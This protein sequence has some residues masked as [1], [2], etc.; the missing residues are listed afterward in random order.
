MKEILQRLIEGEK[1]S[2]QESKEV[3]GNITDNKYNEYEITAF[4]TIY[5]MRPITPKELNGFREALVERAVKV[6]LD[7]KGAIDLC[8]TGGDGK[9][10]FNISTLAALITAGAG[11]RVIKH[12]NYGVSSS[13]GSSN[14]LEACGYTLTNDEKVLQKQLEVGNFCYLH[15][16][17][18]HPSMKAVAP[19][20]RGLGMKTFFNLLGPLVNP[21][22]PEFQIAGVFDTEVA[23][24]YQAILTPIRKNFAVLHSC[25]GYDEISLT[26]NFYRYNQLGEEVINP[27][28]LGFSKV[29]PEELFGGESVEDS[30]KIFMTILEGEGTEAQNS[31]V[32]VNAAAAIHTIKGAE[33]SFADALEEAKESLFG[34]SALNVLKTVCEVK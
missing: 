7:P 28:S 27:E 9:D 15:A 23:E 8:G 21:I 1:L 6:N 20:R 31:A 14:V 29:K 32:L 4:L 25:D 33:T 26:D 2:T 17:L 18:F 10:T 30:K 19:I 12:G 24:L 13:C 3:L 5:M 34:K 22:Q 16:P 11:Y